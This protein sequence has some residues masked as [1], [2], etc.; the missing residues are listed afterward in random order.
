M[1]G[2]LNL[3][4]ITGLCVPIIYNMLMLYVICY[5]LHITY[6]LQPVT[7]NL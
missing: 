7:H 3:T 2:A 4:C 6:D 1:H 5:M